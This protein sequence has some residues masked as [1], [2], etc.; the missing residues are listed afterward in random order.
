KDGRYQY[1]YALGNGKRHT[2]YAKTLSELREKE[3]ELQKDLS[4]NLITSSPKTTLDDLF[5]AYMK[6]KNELK[7]TT[8]NSYKFFY[9]SY[10]KDEIGSMKIKAIKYSDIRRLYSSL[11]SDKGLKPSSVRT[12]HKALRPIFTFAVSDGYIVS[13]PKEGVLKGLKKT[14]ALKKP[15]RHSITIQEQEAFKNFI[16]N[17][18]QYNRL[19]PL[20]MVFLGTGCRV[21]ELIGLR[22]EDCDFEDSTISIN[23][24]LIYSKKADG[25]YGFY[26]TTPKTDA[27]TRII[28]MLKDVKNALL[29]ERKRQMTEGF[30]QTVVDGCKGFIFENINGSLYSGSAI[31]KLITKITEACNSEELIRAEAEHREPL[32][33]RHFS[34][35]SLRHTFCT[36]FCENET[37]LKVIQEIM[38]HA[39]ISITMDIY[40]EATKEKKAESFANLEGKIKI[41]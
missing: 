8:K 26:I 5:K 16:A 13:N 37:N 27:G 21:G 19:L 1:R 40:A 18:P 3:Q 41:I 9:K 24:N 2:I 11:I 31:N 38:G 32:I 17:S 10:I 34:V 15:K 4:N 35:H 36:R 23:H 12:I 14:Y 22:W 6:D 39:N 20:F 28:P 29:F 25:K 33:I 7:L 30:N